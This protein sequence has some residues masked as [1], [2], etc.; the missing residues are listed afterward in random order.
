MDQIVPLDIERMLLGDAP[1]LFLVEICIRVGVIWLWT[2]ALLRWVGGRSIAQLSVVE[3]ILVIALGSA[4]GDPMFQPEVPLLHAMLVILLVVL[5]DKLIDVAF[6][7]WNWAKRFID[8]TPVAVLRDGHILLGGIEA[9]KMGATEVKEMLRLQGV[10]NLGEVE[11]AFLEPSGELSIFRF[12]TP[13]PGLGIVPPFELRE[14]LPPS[15][16]GG[17]CCTT[18]GLVKPFAQ[19]AC[20]CCGETRW[21]DPETQSEPAR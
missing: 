2:V 11:H 4:V 9:R 18:C 20:E 17:A 8:G 19:P 21:T 13:R 6:R 15:G 16:E 7:R 1:L 10:R 5:L 14:P 3:F 12:D